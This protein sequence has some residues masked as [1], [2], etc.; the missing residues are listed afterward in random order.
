MYLSRLILNLRSRQVRSEMADLY[1][2]HRT[3]SRAYPEG[4]FRISRQEDS[5]SGV[6]FRIDTNPHTGIPILLVQ[7]RQKPDW[8]FLQ[9]PEKNYLLAAE[10]LPL[11]IENPS[12]KELDLKFFNGQVLVF[13][14]RANPTVKKD[15]EGMKQGRRVGLV[16]E[17]DQIRWLERKIY[18]AGGTLLTAQASHEAQAKGKLF[19]EKQDE[20]RLCFLA[21]QFDGSLQV[22]NP[23]LFLKTVQA[24]VGSGKGL[25]FGLLSLAPKKR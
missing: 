12:V 8:S 16:R 19:S 13:R 3:I 11:E 14:L 20:K 23:D 24:G 22:K 21:V 5:S 25:G 15:R 6:L 10:D 2:M 17:E 4:T 1:E 18:L 7:S 9:I